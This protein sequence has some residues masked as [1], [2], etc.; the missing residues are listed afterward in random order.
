MLTLTT[1]INGR[2]IP[3]WAQGTGQIISWVEY[4]DSRSLFKKFQ[5]MKICR[6]LET[7]Q[8]SIDMV[9]LLSTASATLHSTARS[10]E[11]RTTNSM[12]TSVTSN[13]VVLEE[14]YQ[15]SL[16]KRLLW[17]LDPLLLSDLPIRVKVSTHK[18]LDQTVTSSSPN[19]KS[20]KTEQMSKTLFKPCSSLKISSSRLIRKIYQVLLDLVARKMCS[21]NVLI[22]PS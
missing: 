5:S 6:N 20:S 9:P 2:V 10:Q 7:T 3:K 22:I 17:K 21:Q 4:Q 8:N 12:D 13:S 11:T 19:D 18:I 15:E 14:I 1:V 16:M